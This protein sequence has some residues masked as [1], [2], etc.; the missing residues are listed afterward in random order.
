M[1]NSALKAL[2]NG[3]FPQYCT[4]CGL[5]AARALP[6]CLACEHDLQHNQYCCHRCAIP[7]P[8]ASAQPAGALCGKCLRAPPPFNRVVA[9]WLYCELLAHLIQ[10]WKYHRE[11]RLTPLLATLWLQANENMG[12]VDVLIPVPLHWRRLLSRG[13]NQADL[14]CRQLRAMSPA[15]HRAQLDH[16]SVRRNRATRAQS[17]SSAVQRHRNLKGA[18]TATRRY[19][20]LRVA[21]VD[22][23]FTTGATAAE[24]AATLRSAGADHI[25]VWCLAR[26]PAP[27]S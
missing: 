4:L 11:Q 13:F 23:V 24:L 7:L 14:L 17:G 16:R 9:P 18:F 8:V 10:L 21:I 27:D 6:L 12:E 25:E 2:L 20:N 15:I 3:L 19:D 1:V 22:D 26:T 5:P